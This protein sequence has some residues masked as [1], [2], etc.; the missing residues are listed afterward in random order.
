[1]PASGV[2]ISASFASALVDKAGLEAVISQA[3]GL[4]AGDYTPESFADMTAALTTAQDV[5]GN[6]AATQEQ[7]DAAAAALEQAINNLVPAS[8]QVDRTE[9]QQLVNEIDQIDL[10]QYTAASAEAM[11]AALS[12]ARAI[13]SDP[14]ATQQQ[15]TDAIN[16]LNTARSQLVPATDPGAGGNTGGN[17][18]GDQTAGSGNAA[19][20]AVNT[21]D[22]TPLWMYLSLAV[23]ALAGLMVSALIKKKR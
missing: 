8:A 18:G 15:I 9:L 13:L 4:V 6:T 11:Q 7:V 20:S 19:N 23:M 10:T 16:A 3:Q 22:N 14:A 2:T 12:S 17:A 21:G 1:M 5:L